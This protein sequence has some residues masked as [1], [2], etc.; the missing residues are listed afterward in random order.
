MQELPLN[1]QFSRGVSICQYMP[2]AEIFRKAK[3]DNQN[4]SPF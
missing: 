3:L 2:R 4:Q 1:V